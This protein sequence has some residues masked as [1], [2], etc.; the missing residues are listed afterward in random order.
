MDEDL[1]RRMRERHQQGLQR[2]AARRA[3]V[4]EGRAPAEVMHAREAAFAVAAEGLTADAR[5]YITTLSY[6]AFDTAQRAGEPFDPAVSG[7]EIGRHIAQVLDWQRKG[8]IAGALKRMR[9]PALD[10]A[11]IGLD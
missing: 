4:A 10:R 5:D 8:G 7:E 1:A 9:F 6:D 3:E 11:S 2:Q